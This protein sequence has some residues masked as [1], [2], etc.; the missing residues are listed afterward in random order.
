MGN[1]RTP[2]VSGDEA[3]VGLYLARDERAVEETQKKYGALFRSIALRLLGNPSDAEECENDAYWHLWNAIPPAKPDS[4]AAYG[5]KTVRNL[6]ISRLEK[7]AAQKRGG[8][9]L[10]AELSDAVPDRRSD[11]YAYADLSGAIDAFLRSCDKRERIMFLLRYFHGYSTE[12]IAEKFGCSPGAVKSQLRRTRNKLK[13]YL[14]KEN[15]K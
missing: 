13:T 12:E 7:D 5:S 3:L 15:S 9:L 10:A 4:L 6:A 14:E 11:D 8:H 2:A 1:E